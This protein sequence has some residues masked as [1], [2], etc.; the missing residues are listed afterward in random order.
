[1]PKPNIAAG[2]IVLEHN[3]KD[4]YYSREVNPVLNKIL[5]DLQNKII[6][7]EEAEYKIKE[8]LNIK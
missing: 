4:T 5:E 3:D 1:M 6:T 2:K 8:W 7:L